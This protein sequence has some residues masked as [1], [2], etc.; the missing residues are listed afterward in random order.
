MGTKAQ[1]PRKICCD[2]TVSYVNSLLR[3]GGLFAIWQYWIVK[4]LNILHNMLIHCFWNKPTLGTHLLFK[5]RKGLLIQWC[6]RAP[7]ATTLW[8]PVLNTTSEDWDKLEVP[9]ASKTIN[10]QEEKKCEEEL[11][12]FIFFN[13]EIRDVVIPEERHDSS[14]SSIWRAVMYEMGRMAQNGLSYKEVGFGW[15]VAIHS[16]MGSFD[17]ERWWT[18]K[19]GAYK[20]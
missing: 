14:P 5:A 20:A 9:R 11:K 3:E 2:S 18:L 1:I 17:S 8:R 10:S 15:T 13:L 4:T 19:G 6:S 16:L 12:V 7:E